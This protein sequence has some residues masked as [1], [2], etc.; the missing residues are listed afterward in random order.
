MNVTLFLASFAM[1]YVVGEHL[2]KTDFLI[3]VDLVIIVTSVALL[4]ACVSAY[5]VQ[6]VSKQGEKE[7]RELQADSLNMALG[8]GIIVMQVLANA[9]ILIPPWFRRRR[10]TRRL[11]EGLLNQSL[12]AKSTSHKDLKPSCSIGYKL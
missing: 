3:S 1:L 8:V 12:S 11:Q 2:P 7:D 6:K 10:N 4:A 5:V 9:L